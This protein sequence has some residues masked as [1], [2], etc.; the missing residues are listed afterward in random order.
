MDKL[1]ERADEMYREQ[2]DEDARLADELK[3]IAADCK[4]PATVVRLLLLCDGLA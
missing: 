1:Q 4:D 3:K 2:R